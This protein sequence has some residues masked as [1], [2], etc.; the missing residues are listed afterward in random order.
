[1][2]KY[3]IKSIKYKTKTMS[4]FKVGYACIKAIKL[5]NTFN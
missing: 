1:M 2:C 5:S 4:D 3:F